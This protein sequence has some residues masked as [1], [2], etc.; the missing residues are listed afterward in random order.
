MTRDCPQKYQECWLWL[1]PLAQTVGQM[2]GRFVWL[3]YIFLNLS[4]YDHILFLF[5]ECNCWSS[6]MEIKR[7]CCWILCSLLS[8]AM[9]NR[10]SR[11]FFS[12]FTSRWGKSQVESRS[13]FLPH[14]TATMWLLIPMKFWNIFRQR[15]PVIQQ[16]Q[17]GYRRRICLKR[18]KRTLTVRAKLKRS[19]PPPTLIIIII[20]PSSQRGGDGRVQQV[21]LSV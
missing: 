10:R 6:N 9:E 16:A 7:Y 20:T 17:M 4:L 5:G 21:C 8:D 19:V 3:G 1:G 14:P 2:K 15:L 13:L 11:T 18:Q 12:Q